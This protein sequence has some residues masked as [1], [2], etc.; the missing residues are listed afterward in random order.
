MSTQTFAK[1]YVQFLAEMGLTFPEIE[2]KCDKAMKT[3]FKDFKKSITPILHQIATRDE[4]IFTDAGVLIAPHVVMTKKLWKDAGK[5]TH[6]AIWDFLSTLTLLATYEEKNATNTVDDNDMDFSKFFDISG[7]DVDLKKMFSS[8][9][10]QFSGKSFSSFFDG[11]KEAAESF[12]DKFADISGGMPMPN[13]PERLF[14]GHIAKIAADLANEFKPEDFGLS[15]DLLN[16]KDTSATFDYLQQIFTKN[17]ELLM[18]G[19]KKIAQRIQDKL[20]K[21][22]VRRE[23]LIREAQELMKE[24]ENNPMFKEIFEQLGS[25]L[26]GMGGDNGPNSDSERRRIVQERLRK[27]ME[28]KKKKNGK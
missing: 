11:I 21:G 14:K 18:R 28:E 26:K 19:A 12:S 10:E 20:K 16:S 17:P 27:K 6:K 3:N 4:S 7:A 15:P 2:K 22:E 13:I 1:V 8:L 23:D 25:Q 5:D 9:G 24:F